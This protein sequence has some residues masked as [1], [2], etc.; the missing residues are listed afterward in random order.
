MQLVS[1][2]LP[3]LLLGGFSEAEVI[4]YLQAKQ[5]AGEEVIKNLQEKDEEKDT[6]LDVSKKE[7]QPEKKLEATE[8]E[9]KPEEEAKN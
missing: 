2:L 1:E 3:F 7:E 5:H 8:S 4:S 6:L 9:N